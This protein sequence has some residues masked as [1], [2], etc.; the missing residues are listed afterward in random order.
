MSEQKTNFSPNIRLNDVIAE[1]VASVEA[2]TPNSTLAVMIKNTPTCILLASPDHHE[3]RY[4]PGN[5]LVTYNG[6]DENGNPIQETWGGGVATLAEDSVIL[7]NP[8]ALNFLPPH[9]EHSYRRDVRGSF[10][11]DG[12]F[13]VDTAQPPVKG[14]LFNEYVSDVPFVT[15][16]YG[17]TP[18]TRWKRGLKQQPIY[19]LQIPEGT[20]DTVVTDPFA[21]TKADL[22]VSAGDYVAIDF[23]KGRVIS[24]HGCAKSWAD[25]TFVP[26][27][28]Y[29][30]D[31]HSTESSENETLYLKA[32]WLI[33]EMLGVHPGDRSRSLVMVASGEPNLV[34]EKVRFGEELDLTKM[35]IA[36]RPTTIHAKDY[37]SGSDL[38]NAAKELP[39][40]SGYRVNPIETTEP[41]YR[42]VRDVSD[43][44]R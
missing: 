40:F 30:R 36:G 23:K 9:E 31:T 4:R 42:V 8:V 27:A 44:F 35:H 19:V 18:T 3:M 5:K 10:A 39:G 34:L 14:R 32:G 38:F 22:T 24:V 1:A 6:V 33:D 12:T 7:R 29:V 2:G 17:V 13:V 37:F 43:C 11:E 15:E 16:A 28:D 41:V 25:R 21:K 20:E 26:H